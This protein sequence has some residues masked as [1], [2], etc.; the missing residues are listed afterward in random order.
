MGLNEGKLFRTISALHLGGIGF[1]AISRRLNSG[2]ASTEE[3]KFAFCSWRTSESS[4]LPRMP[5]R[6]QISQIPPTR[7]RHAPARSYFGGN[8]FSPVP[9]INAQSHSIRPTFIT[10]LP[11]SKY[12]EALPDRLRAAVRHGNGRRRNSVPSDVPES[13]RGGDRPL[14]SGY[15]VFHESITKSFANN[16]FPQN[17]VS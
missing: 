7:S 1:R 3:W 10:I 13:R 14:P 5:H 6:I 11:P 15:P 8:S 4:S 2:K 16:P 9:Y 12:P 17:V